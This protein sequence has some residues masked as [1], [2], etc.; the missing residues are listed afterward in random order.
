MVEAWNDGVDEILGGDHVVMLAY[1]TPASGVV[2]LPLNN[3]AGRDRDAGTISA[4]N[5]SV[6]AWQKLERIRRNPRIALA[7]HSRSHSET[8]RSEYVLVQGRA[9]ISAPVPDYP[10]TIGERWERFES[11]S[12]TPALWKRWQRI[13]AT[14]VAIDV[15]VERILV[16]PDLSCSGELTVTGTPLPEL[17]LADQREPA[18]GAG[19]RLDAEQAAARAARL[20]HVLL[21]WIGEDG[22]PMA[23]PV[24]VIGSAPEGISLRAS[25]GLVPPGARR[26]GLTAHWFAAGA[27]GQNQRKHTGWLT[28]SAGGETLLYAPHT[29]SAYRFPTSRTLYRLASGA[30]GRLGVRG[31]RRAGFLT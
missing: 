14:R 7:Y 19:P 18:K 17:P 2:L 10:A 21:G 23:V 16:W 30:S 20:P 28:A 5:S 29:Q 9:S 26:G 22:Y 12:S 15:E 3:F 8:R 6:G 4:I 13:Y 27:I 1:A 25:A 11:W 31:A 24:E